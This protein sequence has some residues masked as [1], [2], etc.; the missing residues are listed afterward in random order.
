M[1]HLSRMAVRLF[2]FTALLLPSLLEYLTDYVSGGR[3]RS[4][5]ITKKK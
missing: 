5:W 4:W 3:Y 2:F 1:T